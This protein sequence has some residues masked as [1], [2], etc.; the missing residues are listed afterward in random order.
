MN[1]P[2]RAA[3]AL[4]LLGLVPAVLGFPPLDPAFI[5][6]G[7]LRDANSP[8]SGEYDLQFSLWDAAVG[9]TQVGSTICHDNVTVVDG[10]VTLPL[11]FGAAVFDGDARWVEVGV[12]AGGTPGDCASGVY[13]V[14]S[15]RQPLAPA[16]YALYALRTPWSGLIDVPEGFADGVDDIGGDITAVIAGAGLSGGGTSGDVTL[17]VAAGGILPPMIALPFSGSVASPLPVWEVINT[18]AGV[19]LRGQTDGAG[20]ALR[21]A[22]TG[23]G[24]A[25]SMLVTQEN[26]ASAGPAIAAIAGGTGD[27]AVL[28]SVGGRA[29][30]ARI[31]VAANPSDAIEADTVGAGDAL[32]A[33]NNGTGSAIFASI[34]VGA[35]ASDVLRAQTLGAGAAIRARN[36]GTGAAVQADIPVAGNASNVIQATTVSTGRAGLFQITNAASAVPVVEATTDSTVGGVSALLATA[37]G[38][39]GATNGVLGQTASGTAGAAGV[40]ADAT[41]AAP[42]GAN[43]GIRAINFGAL[44]VVRGGVGL[45]VSAGAFRTYGLQ[46]QTNAGGPFAAGLYGLANNATPVQTYGVRGQNISTL[47]SAAGVLGQGNGVLGPGVPNA[48]ALEISNGAIRVSGPVRPAGVAC[49]PPAWSPIESCINGSCGFDPNPHNHIIGWYTDIPLAN[50]LIIPGGCPP[51]V[52]SVIQATVETAVP[53]PPC[54]SWYVQVHSKA[55]GAC[56]LRVSRMGVVTP[57]GC[58]PP[59]E[60]FWVNYVIINQAPLGAAADAGSEPD[61]DGASTAP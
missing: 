36:F 25:A 19:A 32:F 14:L 38:P 35:N 52:G 17:A 27:G 10:L 4:I 16:P 12:R 50:P 34:P 55:P 29:L 24:P 43:Y 42:A 2:C 47:D 53:P 49:G 1:L 26:A 3:L 61:A 48:A 23:V 7:R 15:P 59:T 45:A 6:Q 60:E 11:D 20:N 8:A 28:E 33:Q 51:E 56:M 31:T 54:T 40:R 46:G 21:A 58:Y 5:Y 9:G 30:L 13:T 22:R 39:T 18:G 37:T 44:D 41:N 57:C